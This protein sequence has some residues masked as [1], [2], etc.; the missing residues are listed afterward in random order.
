MNNSSTQNGNYIC[1]QSSDTLD[2]TEVNLTDLSDDASVIGN[3]YE[4]NFSYWNA[5]LHPVKAHGSEWS[6][7]DGRRVA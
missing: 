6:Q 3:P 7:F 1:L 2:W 5:L 4:S